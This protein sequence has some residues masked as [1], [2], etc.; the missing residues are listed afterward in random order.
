MSS[1]PT[2]GGRDTAP[3]ARGREVVVYGSIRGLLAATA[4][5]ALLL[6]LGFGALANVGRFSVVPAVLIGLGVALA[7]G[8]ALDYPRRTRF[9]VDGISRICALRVHHLPWGEVVAIER[10][11]RSASGRVRAVIADRRGQTHVTGGLVALSTARRRYLLVDRVEGARE[12]DRIQQLLR[13]ADIATVLR[14]KRPAEDTPPT[15]LY[16]RSSRR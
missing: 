8:L 12:H 4:T 2:D 7:A 6:A 1:S 15:D 5:P 16:R 10:T 9:D 13:D 14:A 3:D 11:P